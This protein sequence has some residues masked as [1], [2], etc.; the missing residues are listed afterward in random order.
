MIDTQRKLELASRGSALL[1]LSA[2]RLIGTAGLSVAKILE[3]MEDRPQRDVRPGG[4]GC[5]TRRSTRP[6]GSGTTCV[7]S[8]SLEALHSEIHPAPTNVIGGTT[9]WLRDHAGRRGPAGCRFLQ[10]ALEPD[11]RLP[12]PSTAS[13]PTD[14]QLQKGNWKGPPGQSEFQTQKRV[15]RKIPGPDDQDYRSIRPCRGPLRRPPSYPN[16]TADLVPEPLDPLGAIMWPFPGVA[17]FE[18]S[19]DRRRNRAD[20][21]VRQMLGAANIKGLSG[22]ASNDRASPSG[23]GDITCF[24]DLPRQ[25]LPGIHAEG[26]EIFDRYDLPYGRQLPRRWLRHP[27]R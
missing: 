15:I 17:T 3:N 4:T 22:D 14:L 1:A 6:P 21:Y 2:G 20:W 18:K 9:T 5:G 26:Q 11:Q 13:P 12:L 19:V 25:P 27:E 16:L 8:R 24:P 7:S 23:S 10:P